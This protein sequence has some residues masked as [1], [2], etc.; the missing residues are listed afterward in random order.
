M[1]SQEMNILPLILKYNFYQVG[2]CSSSAY[3]LIFWSW[4]YSVCIL[5]RTLAMLTLVF[6]V[7][8]QYLQA[9]SGLVNQLGHSCFLSSSSFA[10]HLSVQCCTVELLITSYN[11]LQRNMYT[12]F[13]FTHRN[14]F[15][16]SAKFCLSV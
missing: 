7:S 9:N 13:K 15:G 2:W 14:Y 12:F 10:S 6:H 16:I 3:N 11:N 4:R 5:A 1:Q 8:P